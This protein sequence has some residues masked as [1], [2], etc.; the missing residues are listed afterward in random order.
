MKHY[1][2]CLLCL[3]SW[4]AFSQPTKTIPPSPEAT[5][6]FKFAEVPVSLYTGVP[7]TAIEIYQV[8]TKGIILPVTVSYHG[9][10]IQ[11][12]EIA[13]RVGM[14]WSLSYGGMISRQVRDRADDWPWGLL[15]HSNYNEMFTDSSKR[16]NFDWNITNDNI[17]QTPD[18][19]FLDMNGENVKFT[20]DPTD[21][22]ILQQKF[23]NTQITPLYADSGTNTETG[24]IGWI[25]RDKHGNT[26]YYGYSKD[27]T[28]KANDYDQPLQNYVYTNLDNAP[29]ISQP[30]EVVTPINTW[31]L[32]EIETPYQERIEFHYN[33][34]VSETLRRSYDKTEM[35]DYHGFSPDDE[36]PSDYPAQSFASLIRSMQYQIKEIKFQNGRVVF[37][38]QNSA[39]EDIDGDP[40]GIDIDWEVTM[41]AR[42]LKSISIL[43]ADG[44]LLK[45]FSFQHRYT[46]STDN[47]DLLEYWRNLALQSDKRLFLTSIEEKGNN[48][49]RKPA[50]L[51][52]YS[53]IPLPN[54]FSNSQDSW[55]YYNNKPNG[56]FLTFFKYGNHTISRKV[57]TV[58][59]EAGLLKKIIYPTGGSTAFTYE[60]N[61]AIP[62]DFMGNL[63]YLGTNPTLTKPRSEGI[64]K[65]DK[66]YHDGV[67]T[68]TLTV[69]P[70]IAGVVY[71][72]MDCTS[73]YGNSGGTEYDDTPDPGPC[74]YRVYLIDELNNRR[75]IYYPNIPINKF[76]VLPGRYTLEVVPPS[77]YDHADSTKFFYVT[78]GWTEIKTLGDGLLYAAGKRIKKIEYK[79][80]DKTVQVKEYHYEGGQIFGLPNF[81]SIDEKITLLDGQVIPKLDPYGSTAG[82]PLTSLQGNSVG[83]QFVTEY[84]GDA[85]T[86]Y[87][88]TEYE[89]TV[90]RDGGDFFKFPY[91]I[92]TDN[93]WLRGKNIQTRIFE[94]VAGVYK[95]KRSIVNNYTYEGNFS[96]TVGFYKP[97]LQPGQSFVY[98]KND[99]AFYR[100]Y[101]ILTDDMMNYKTFYVTGGTLDLF[102]SV[103]T[104]YYPEDRTLQKT[105]NYFYDYKRHY[106]L[107]RTETTD[108]KF[109]KLVSTTTYPLSVNSRPRTA[110]EQELVAQ[111]RLAELLK[112]ETM[113]QDS[114]GRELARTSQQTGF[115]LFGGLV[116]PDSVVSVINDGP[117]QLEARFLGY[118]LQGNVAEVVGRDGIRSRYLW[119]YAD[120]YPIAQVLNADSSSF[121]YTSFEA[122]GTGGWQFSGP[123]LADTTSPTGRKG[124]LLSGGSVIHA[125]SDSVRSYVVSL[126]SKGA[127]APLVNQAGPTY[128]GRTVKGWTL[129][130]YLVSGGTSVTVSSPASAGSDKVQIDE[131]RLYPAGAQMTTYTYDPLVGMTSATDPNGTTTYYEYDGF[132]RLQAVKDQEGNVLKTY[133]YHFQG[134]TNQ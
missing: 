35:T 113:V 17:D 53:D 78:L 123:V 57:D 46:V 83:Y 32:M 119:D 28:R 90:P 70:D 93:E 44:S 88:K 10:G 104:D 82:S 51:F 24:I 9:R 48:G 125:V 29:T 92:P 95:L 73:F 134:H 62:P 114:T 117:W 63:V 61:K 120:S 14:G 124:Y 94:Q 98:S 39:R 2:T 106:Q 36:S 7:N 27:R 15:A 127:A 43:Q 22:S 76:E 69:G 23:D 100:P 33:L 128:T 19:F 49:I 81:Y 87:G 103:E 8:K 60:H 129:R 109:E 97:F 91:T 52:E 105:T 5:A 37:T 84:F 31:H 20:F 102:Q 108:S 132:G 6:A 110:A 96:A 13:S 65:Q 130:H 38:P 101:L 85:T 66:Y 45:E 131:L 99:S 112:T 67:Y 111:H 55:G 121:A 133:Q 64:M 25:V 59:A 12:E 21:K 80:P 58:M 4:V 77:G 107:A 74:D 42:A 86:N 71:V 116:L 40:S 50:Y 72:S 68:D 30:Q 79:N 16:Q 34:E 56:R 47:T 41:Q 75:I 3:L 115:S 11:V 54:R 89:F 26:F 122:D 18:Q 1:F 118:D 126:W